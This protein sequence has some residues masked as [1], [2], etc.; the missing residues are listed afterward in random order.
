LPSLLLPYFV[1][2]LVAVPLVLVDLEAARIAKSC[3][4]RHDIFPV[5][6]PVA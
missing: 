6:P 5:P 2:N 4:F 3:S 1:Q